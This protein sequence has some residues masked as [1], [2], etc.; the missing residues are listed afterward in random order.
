MIIEFEP[1]RMLMTLPPMWRLYYKTES[2]TDFK[3]MYVTY[4]QLK[5]FLEIYGYETNDILTLNKF[6]I[7]TENI[8][9]NKNLK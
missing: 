5:T 6:G 7:N 9:Y 3:M 2:D 1:N 8:L 4:A